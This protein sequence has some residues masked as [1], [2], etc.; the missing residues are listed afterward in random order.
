MAVDPRRDEEHV[1][2]SHGVG[3]LREP[4]K[5]S[6]GEEDEHELREEGVEV[7]EEE[8]VGGHGRE[9]GLQACG[10]CQTEDKQLTAGR[11]GRK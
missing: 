11:E 2:A 10:D 9:G 1:R 5:D 4:S 8:G 6:A 7:G 3:G